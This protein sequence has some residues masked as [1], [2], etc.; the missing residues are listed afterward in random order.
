MSWGGC[1]EAKDCL[2]TPHR[3]PVSS[4]RAEPR[5]NGTTCLARSK[6]SA[7]KSARIAV[8]SGQGLPTPPQTDDRP[9]YLAKHTR[10]DPSA[11]EADQ[12]Y[13]GRTATN[14]VMATNAGPVSVSRESL[15][16]ISD[17]GRI[18]HPAGELGPQ[19]VGVT[20]ASAR[21]AP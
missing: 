9:V 17:R 15:W 19:T 21:R 6:G 12:F 2:G 7:D 5:N 18:R 20:T 10:N 1:G 13:A 8:L 3:S 4:G 16:W 11:V 14:L